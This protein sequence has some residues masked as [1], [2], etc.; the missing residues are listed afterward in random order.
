MRSTPPERHG[1][2][3]TESTRPRKHYVKPA[4]GKPVDNDE[5]L[6]MGYALFDKIAADQAREAREGDQPEQ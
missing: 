6:A 3:Q 5:A 1:L 2:G 4:Q